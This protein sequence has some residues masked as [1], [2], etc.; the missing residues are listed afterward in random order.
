MKLKKLMYNREV[1]YTHF[2]F[3]LLHLHKA[4]NVH[5]MQQ[6]GDLW[7][8]FCS[9]RSIIILYSESGYLKP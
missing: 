4:G 2:L 1:F 3:C 7:N 6:S 8:H 9:R 5:F